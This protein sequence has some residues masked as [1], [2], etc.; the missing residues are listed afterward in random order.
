MA[1]TSPSHDLHAVFDLPIDD[2]IIDVSQSVR[3]RP[4]DDE[5]IRMARSLGALGQLQNVLVIWRGHAYELVTGYARAFAIRELGDRIGLR[6]IR[7]MSIAVEEVE[8]ARL[9]ENFIR[10]TPGT[11]ELAKFLAGFAASGTSIPNLSVYLGKSEE[12]VRGLLRLFRELPPNVK[13]AWE[14]DRDQR[15]TFER[16]NDLVRLKQAG[17]IAGLNARLEK[18]LATPSKRRGAAANMRFGSPERCLADAL[19]GCGLVQQENGALA[20]ASARNEEKNEKR[21]SRRMSRRQLEKMEARLGSITSDRLTQFT[22]GADTF[23][24]FVCAVLGKAPRSDAWSIVE[25]LISEAA[26][27]SGG[28]DSDMALDVAEYPQQPDF[29][30][31]R[32]GGS[33]P[34]AD[35]DLA[36]DDLDDPA[37]EAEMEDDPPTEE[38][39]AAE[40]RQQPD[41]APF[42]SSDRLDSDGASAE[43]LVR[44]VD[45]VVPLASAPEERRSGWSNMD[46]NSIRR[47]FS[48]RTSNER[49]VGS[50]DETAAGPPAPLVSALKSRRRSAATMSD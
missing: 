2:L 38:L 49:E 11:F 5:V 36:D 19:K 15:L 3:G 42:P 31:S 32:E 7:A 47:H 37:P 24:R 25:R 29:M 46:N 26:G 33:L 8:L 39:L 30:D 27:E 17:D 1:S 10:R 9:S 43:R 41:S 6:T 18:I 45:A 50:G 13:A 20:L 23:H 21:R 34:L 16:L 35:N 22:V 28:D 4:A 48:E 44:D 40:Y 14:A 12:Y